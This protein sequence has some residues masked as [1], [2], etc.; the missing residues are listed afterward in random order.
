[1]EKHNLSVGFVG[2]GFNRVCGH[3]NGRPAIEN[4]RRPI[5]SVQPGPFGSQAVDYVFSGGLLV[6]LIG[7][8]TLLW[9]GFTADITST[10]NRTE[11]LNLPKV[12]KFNSSIDK[13]KPDEEKKDD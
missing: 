9:N 2:H 13:S 1:M 5:V 4:R 3:R 7:A 11:G 8:G 10:P 6:I 12:D